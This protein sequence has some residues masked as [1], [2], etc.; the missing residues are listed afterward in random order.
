MN[1]ATSSSPAESPIRSDEMVGRLDSLLGMELVDLDGSSFGT[2]ERVYWRTSDGTPEWCAASVG[3]LD[4]NLVA[5]PLVDATIDDKINVPYPKGMI[6]SAPEV[7]GG[8]ITLEREM[9]WY[10]Y[11]NIRRELSG[12]T[13]NAVPAGPPLASWP[14]GSSP[15][16]SPEGGSSEASAAMEPEISEDAIRERAYAIY[17][18]RGGQDGLHEDDWRKA[19]AELRGRP[20]F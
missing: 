2:C 1:E 19:E 17:L 16:T 13:D 15:R 7:N 20:L 18:E 14:E 10:R 9:N 5:V 3:L 8:A 12:A 6:A 11:Y 4:K